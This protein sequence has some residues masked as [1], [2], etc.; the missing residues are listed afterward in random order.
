MF[1]ELKNLSKHS[2]VYML[3][4][5][6]SRMVGFLMIP[7][8]TRYLTP[9]D[10]G[11]LE[12]V[13]LTIDV[14]GMLA[15]L[16]V[17]SAITRFYYEYKDR[18][19]RDEVITTGLLSTI[20]LASVPTA[21]LIV[22]AGW[23]S[24]L[25]FDDIQYGYFFQLL[26]LA[27]FLDLVLV[28]PMTV[29]TIREKSTTYVIFSLIRLALSLSLNI[30][31]VVVLE[32]GVVGI[33]YSSLISS[34]VSCVLLCLTVFVRMRIRFSLDKAIKMIKFG[35]PLVAAA[36]G[37]FVLNFADRY[38]LEH[39]TSL[40]EVGL[41]GLGYKFAI[42]LSQLLH[43]PFN[44]MWNVFMFK[45]ADRPDAKQMY[46]RVMTYN[47]FVV[48][49]VALG[50]A[51][52]IKDVLKIMVTPEF[53]DAHRIVPLI[54]AGFYFYYMMPILDVGIMLTKKTYLRAM[55]VTI[56]AIVNLGLNYI[57]ISRFD[58]MGAAYATFL[59]YSFLA[60]LTLYVSGRVLSVPYE[61]FRLAKMY[62]SALLIFALSRMIDSDSLALTI[63]AKTAVVLM[64]P[65]VLI[66]LKFYDEKERRKIAELSRQFAGK[67]LR[68]NVD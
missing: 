51:V 28:I 56:A 3:G 37:T 25:V 7:V 44:L 47:S 29:L 36:L 62:V 55:N 6:A 13:S 4:S 65:L 50:M 48:I 67:L 15:A 21:L 64:F 42:A 52:L 33:L 12:L 24:T 14:V 58:M 18:D 2:L 32:M 23:L 10:Y 27:N 9:S 31:F 16:G 1:D 40:R 60:I 46:A 34:A 17:N 35:S 11:V 43:G 19:Q 26:L 49:F 68:R 63:A 61:Y 54:L 5:I 22:K 57:L 39:F 53:Q 38:F 8:Y 45:I 66:P 59:S 20:V 30:Y 41:Y